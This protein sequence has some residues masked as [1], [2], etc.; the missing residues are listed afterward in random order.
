MKPK[1]Y[2]YENELTDDFAGTDITTKTVP[3]NFRYLHKGPLWLC[4]RAVAYMLALPVAKIVSFLRYGTRIKN[5]RVLQA[6]KGKGYFIYANHTLVTGDAFHPN[7]VGPALKTRIIV[8]ADAVSLPLLKNLV[9]MLGG[10]PLPGSRA[11][12]RN[13]L[14]A[15][16]THLR[17]KN[18][19]VIYP[20]A[21]IWPY[22]TGIRPFTSDSFLYPV[23]FD[24]PVF[25]LT[26]V[27]KKRRFRKLPKCILYVD[28]P[29]FPDRSLPALERKTKLRNEV[30]AVMSE[31]SKESDY[32]R[33]IYV[34]RPFIEESAE[35]VTYDNFGV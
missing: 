33:V 27:H 10:M 5:K 18:A 29:F 34:K 35:I 8:G 21:H 30:Y 17:H 25:A 4:A 12:Y 6:A 7:L 20:E 32:D 22:Y 11:G 23:K 28:G 3:D 19:I 31:R 26:T 1:I 9:V 24:S 16:Q 2:Y 15:M 14:S 13:F